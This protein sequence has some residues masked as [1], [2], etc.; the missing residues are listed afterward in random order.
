MADFNSFFSNLSPEAKQGLLQT[1]L[2]ILASPSYGNAGQQIGR[3]GLLGMQGYNAAR[4]IGILDAAQKSRDQYRKDTLAVEAAKLLAAQQDAQRVRNE[5][6]GSPVAP[7]LPGPA[8]DT[9]QSTDS[10]IPPFSGF[11]L[12]PVND[13]NYQD[14]TGLRPDPSAFGQVGP[15]QGG[16]QGLT[17]SGSDNLGMGPSNE[18]PT[19]VANSARISAPGFPD[20]RRD[21]ELDNFAAHRGST[22]P[23]TGFTNF[24]EGTY[25]AE[26]LR[27]AEEGQ[28]INAE[29]MALHSV[30]QFEYPGGMQMP[31][32]QPSAVPPAP[33][34][35]L[36]AA[37]AALNADKVGAQPS[38][39][40]SEVDRL[41]AKR[42]ELDV[43]IDRMMGYRD[44]ESHGK[45]IDGLR[46]ER[47]NLQ[48]RIDALD[49]D[50]LVWDTAMHNGKRE[51]FRKDSAGNFVDWTGMEPDDKR[52]NIKVSASANAEIPEDQ[53]E[54]VKKNQAEQSEELTK[55][56]G[57][58][59][60]AWVS[61][62]SLDR[63]VKE[64]DT[65]YGGTLAGVMTQA[66]R[67]FAS[68]GAEFEN[69]KSA[70]AMTSALNG[71]MA[72]KFEELG[73]RGLTDP[74]VK[75]LFAHFP[76]I[77]TSPESR[78]NVARILKKS[79]DYVVRQY[80]EKLRWIRSP[81]G[82]PDSKQ[83]VPS[84]LKSWRMK[85]VPEN[86]F[87]EGVTQEVW[88]RMDAETRKAMKAG[89]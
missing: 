53:S 72:T 56:K 75:I 10:E 58:G 39:Q 60:T 34:S 73:A 21:V 83:Q 22:T 47:T 12:P 43:E 55:M 51:F 33:V 84:W 82:Y 31:Q 54:F 57:R 13:V 76:Y 89:Q 77:N 11:T 61:N 87:Y 19:L 52:N 37:T 67:F 15:V 14:T 71:L 45:Y 79:N 36:G 70:D 18:I 85:A 69:L 46:K 29:R 16:G 44:P 40:S 32:I 7:G 66:Q 78:V 27:R 35:N 6:A 41:T 64:S 24:Q 38:A 20:T 8:P 68:F 59:H 26:A 23:N 42:D 81:D 48:A 1:G 9:A 50:G 86:L 25:K 62:R 17:P 30:P 3:G 80:S 2:G 88:D 65:A 63:F 49:E 4:R 74:D 5:R 28:R